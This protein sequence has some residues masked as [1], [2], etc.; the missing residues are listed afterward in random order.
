MHYVIATFIVGLSFFFAGIAEIRGNL[1]QLASRRFRKLLS[2]LTGRPVLSAVWGFLFGAIT[3]SSS[4]VSFILSGFISSGV[5]TVRQALPVVAWSNLGTVVLVFLA[6]VDINLGVLY[7]LGLSGL[8]L[9]FYSR[10]EYRPVISAL[11]GMGLLFFGLSMMKHAFEP[12]PSYEWF[13]SVASFTQSSG[14]LIFIFGLLLRVVIQSSSA[15]AVIAITLAQSGLFQEG[16]TIL[17]IYSTGP[18]V[19]LAILL[20]SADL[21]GVP[22]QVT[23]FQGIIHGVAGLTALG[24]YYLEGFTGWP[25]P[26]HWIA[27][28]PGDLDTRL[29]FAFLFLQML[30]TGMGLLFSRWALPYLE[31]ISPATVE[32]DLSQPEFLHDQG[33][34]DPETGLEMVEQEQARLL[35]WMPGYLDV[36]RP[37]C[38]FTPAVPVATLH[39]AT[40]AVGLEIRSFLAELVKQGPDHEKSRHLLDLERRQSLIEAMEENL[41]QMTENLSKRKTSGAVQDSLKN[42]VEGLHAI[43]TISLGLLDP[44]DQAGVDTLLVITEDR[45]KMMEELRQTCLHAE[46]GLNHSDKATLFYVTGL[47]ERT[48]WVLHQMA[49]ALKRG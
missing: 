22:R 41:Y 28:V 42:L 31:K 43:L 9:V 8:I 49:L 23:L 11:Y 25:G 10:W 34:N 47:F 2:K 17:M 26:R 33:L 45:S 46:A 48:V 3:Q 44:N 19:C 38:N 4:A 21:K 14:L 1:Q 7:L 20:L 13:K 18:G 29:S 27:A 32:Q 36:L 12:L 30:T 40:R 6:A 24:L 37:D 16:E 15:I 35:R 39:S 5:V